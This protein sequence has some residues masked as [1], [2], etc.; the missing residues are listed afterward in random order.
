MAQAAESRQKLKQNLSDVRRRMAEAARRS[1]R[2]PGAVTL[3]AV[4]KT[5]AAETARALIE[6]GVS[7][8]GENRVQEARAK[9]HRLADCPVR[10]HMI[11]HLQRNKAREAVRLFALI[12]SVDSGR[13][14]EALQRRAAEENRVV[15]VLLEVNTSGEAAKFGAAPAEL[16]ELAVAV[17]ASAHL[18]LRGLMTMAPIVEE[19]EL[20]RPY[21]A[22]LRELRDRTNA[23]GRLRKPMTEL[24]M[25]M[26][27]DFEVAI[28]EGATMVRIGSA[29]FRGVDG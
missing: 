6:L 8:L 5:V 17:D 12:H 20:A 2:P 18:E 1:G 25:G 28:E 21:F 9:V 10:W 14:A 13:L 4:T 3:V 26:T 16:E 11:G 22:R 29:L 7:D 27:Q 24:S 23:C 15:P 19:P